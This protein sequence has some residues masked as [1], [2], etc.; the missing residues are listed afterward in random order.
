MLIPGVPESGA[1]GYKGS[2]ISKHLD[3][4][5]KRKEA[6]YDR[7][8]RVSEG[9]EWRGSTRVVYTYMRYHLISK[10]KAHSDCQRLPVEK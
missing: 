3:C 1:S 4:W 6:E 5:R 8:G 10:K 2:E 7:V 9:K